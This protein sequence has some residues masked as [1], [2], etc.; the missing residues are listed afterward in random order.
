MTHFSHQ[1][2]SWL[3][4]TKFR[5]RQTP[6]HRHACMLAPGSYQHHRSHCHVLE[7][8]GPHACIS[9]FPLEI[10]HDDCSLRLALLSCPPTRSITDATVAPA[11]RGK[12]VAFN[13]ALAAGE[14]A[15]TA[16]ATA[17][18]PAKLSA[19]LSHLASLQS[20]GLTHIHLL[21][22]YDFGSV[23][24]RFEE[25]GRVKVS[26]W[27]IWRRSQ[28][29]WTERILAACVCVCVVLG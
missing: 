27:H 14:A 4:C 17:I 29:S 24:E 28:L 11:A 13:A 6:L 5:V 2:L 19:G 12:Y 16:T 18:A 10:Q 26:H 20:A 9:S 21:P 23:P 25:Q 1:P 15:P 22:V 8:R 3:W 7:P